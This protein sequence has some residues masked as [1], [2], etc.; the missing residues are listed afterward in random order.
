MSHLLLTEK[1]SD[2]TVE[3]T[4]ASGDPE[5]SYLVSIYAK[6]PEGRVLL[7]K[8]GYNEEVRAVSYGIEL[9]MADLITSSKSG[10]LPDSQERWDSYEWV[11]DVVLRTTETTA[12]ASRFNSSSDV[13]RAVFHVGQRI[14]YPSYVEIIGRPVDLEIYVRI[15]HNALSALPTYFLKFTVTDRSQDVKRDGMTL[16]S[17]S[18]TCCFNYIGSELRFDEDN[19]IATFKE[20]LIVA[21]GLEGKPE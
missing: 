16:S 1:Y 14:C 13:T 15:P 8:E 3:V 4:S 6:H 21:L 7:W 17:S 20:E 9:A 10:I 11:R 12:F 2:L 18:R 5:I 19:V